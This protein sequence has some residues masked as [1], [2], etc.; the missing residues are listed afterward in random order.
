MVQHVESRRGPSMARVRVSAS[1]RR[2]VGRFAA[3]WVKAVTSAVLAMVCPAAMA[4]PDLVAVAAV[5][6]RARQQ[7]PIGLYVGVRSSL[8]I[9]PPE[10]ETGDGDTVP[11]TSAGS[12]VPRLGAEAG[13][14][15]RGADR[16][17]VSLD[18]LL[19]P[20]SVRLGSDA[21]WGPPATYW[22]ALVSGG[23]HMELTN[24]TAQ[25]SVGLRLSKSVLGGWGGTTSA[26]RRPYPVPPR[27]ASLLAAA[28]WRPRVG[29][30][31]DWVLQ[32]GSGLP[33]LSYGCNQSVGS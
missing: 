30:R 1:T 8:F 6:V 29:S 9:R 18:G 16:L 19:G 23:L 26:A 31:D 7:H 12:I 3:G 13:V 22:D 27:G 20:A 28:M 4:A 17:G 15:W 11:C 33:L 24:P 21:C 2:P 5:E 10:C 25:P 32:A 14:V